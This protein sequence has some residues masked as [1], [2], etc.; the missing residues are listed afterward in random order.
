MNVNHLEELSWWVYIFSNPTMNGMLKIEISSKTLAEHARAGDPMPFPVEYE[1]KVRNFRRVA[2]RLNL[3]LEKF[4]TRGGQ[5]GSEFLAC[6]LS[7]AIATVRK[8]CANR[9]IFETCPSEAAA[10]IR[11]LSEI[12]AAK[13]APDSV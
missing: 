4:R 9:I 8:I 5:F 13:V 1:A 6:G 7:E 11:R 10:R 3:E 2:G 12:A